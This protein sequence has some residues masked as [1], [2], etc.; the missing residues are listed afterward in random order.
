M[1]TS[2]IKFL[3]VLV[4]QGYARES[5]ELRRRERK[6]LWRKRQIAIEKKSFPHGSNMGCCLS[7]WCDDE[8]NYETSLFDGNLLTGVF[9]RLTPIPGDVSESRWSRCL[10][11]VRAHELFKKWVGKNEEALRRGGAWKALRRAGIV[12]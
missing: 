5:S 2:K 1:V 12:K 8:G 11:F 3:R 10:T 7:D 4:G 9:R 6:R